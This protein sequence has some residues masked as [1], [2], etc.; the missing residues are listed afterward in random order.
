MM[1]RP[2]RLKGFVS[3][4]GA[5]YI[6]YFRNLRSNRSY[7]KEEWKV[8]NDSEVRSYYYFKELILEC[9]ETM[10]RPTLIFYERMSERPSSFA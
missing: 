4:V 3:F 9:A 6:C 1:F 8:Y 5:H 7:E 10:Q 2:Y